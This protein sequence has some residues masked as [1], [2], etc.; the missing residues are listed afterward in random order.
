MFINR[1]KYSGEDLNTEISSRDEYDKKK[2]ADEALVRMNQLVTD[3]RNKYMIISESWN[4]VIV[5][6][7]KKRNALMY[8]ASGELELRMIIEDLFKERGSFGIRYN[9]LIEEV[10]NFGNSL[11]KNGADYRSIEQILPLIDEIVANSKCLNINIYNVEGLDNVGPQEF[12]ISPRSKEIINSWKQKYQTIPELKYATQKRELKQ[13][14]NE[15]KSKLRDAESKKKAE[16]AEYLIMK[17][18]LDSIT[19][20]I[21]ESTGQVEEKNSKVRSSA[22]VE[23]EETD[24]KLT[25]YKEAAKNVDA[26]IAKNKEELSK[27]SFF[28]RAQKKEIQ[29]KIDELII[30]RRKFTARIRE[31]QDNIERIINERDSKLEKSNRGVLADKA[32]VRELTVAIARTQKDIN[33]LDREIN[34]LQVEIDSKCEVIRQLEEKESLP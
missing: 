20:R 26:E 15:L 2:K 3:F 25:E 31:V 32:K 7:Q 17:G 4:D 10:G 12:D 33:E 5:E 9:A 23:L 22:D 16:E 19:E 21:N 24:K 8:N 18:N 27:L 11:L 13:S 1:I 30:T 6:F 34:A 14:I 29:N 28:K